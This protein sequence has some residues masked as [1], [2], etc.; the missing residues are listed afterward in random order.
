MRSFYGYFSIV[1]AMVAIKLAPVTVAVSIMMMMVFGSAI[2]GFC[3][4]GEKLGC[5]EVVAMIG[6]FFGV[7]TLTNA[8][9]IFPHEKGDDSDLRDAAD[10]KKYPHEEMGI[11]FA[12]LYCLFS[13]ANLYEMRKMGKRVHTSIKTFY[14]GLLCSVFTLVYIAID[15]PKFFMF[16]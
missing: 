4:A 2:C 10:N 14:F 7:L 8:H 3:L 5:G 12:F 13:V 11:C 16:W 15:D 6:G 1:G 9:L